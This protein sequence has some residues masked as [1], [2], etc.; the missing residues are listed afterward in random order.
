[1]KNW[2]QWAER[3]PVLGSIAGWPK[4][5]QLGAASALLTL[6]IGT[7]LW[8]GRPDY[9]VLFANLEDRDG[10]AIVT[11]LG[12]MNIPYKLAGTGQAI[13]VPA[14]KVHEVRLL[15]AQQGLPRSGETGFGLLDQTRFGASQ[16][17]EQI[18]Y[19]RALEGELAHS[20]EAVHAVQSARVHL[21]LPRESLFVRERQPPT[22]SVLL[23][24]YPGRSLT[25]AQVSAI[26]WL[27]SSSVPHLTS[28]KVSVVDQNGRLLTPP[29]GE[30]GADGSRR[31]LVNEI[32]QR[33]AQRILTLLSPL[34]GAS[35]VQAQVSADVD[36]VQRE[37][38]SEVYRPNQLPGEAAVRSKQTSASTQHN[39][40]PPQ[41][42]PGAL[43]NQPPVNATAPIQ[44]P[45][46]PVPVDG[47]VEASSELAT[48]GAPQQ[49]SG[50][51]RQDATINYEVDR[52]IRHTKQPLGT[53]RRLS[54]AV[55]INDRHL[56]DRTES[57][58][59]ETL[60]RLTEL[61]RQAMGYSAERG[62][63]LSVVSMPF[64]DAGAAAVPLWQNPIYLDYGMDLIRYLLIALG[65]YL[66]W[67]A[68]V[69]PLLTSSKAAEQAGA[70]PAGPTEEEE[71]DTAAE[72]LA[73]E[74]SRYE[75]N[76]KTARTLAEKDPRA[77]AMVLRAWMEKTHDNV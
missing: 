54:V 70:L 72:R 65:V 34:V 14:D 26:S 57:V 73:S 32:E 63:T 18:T 19:Q 4:P 77:V 27:V 47:A 74:L 22:A 46:L 71:R 2:A 37:E 21:A 13:M 39:M 48:A 3:F 45:A 66:A 62:D 68:L 1:M 31:S 36:F 55:V 41:G 11:A 69:R 16:F 58:S 40:L 42:V 76:L 67:R 5:V 33:T 56:E 10:G 12:Q 60:S 44:A 9:R 51:T 6:I 28:E 7:L 50:A 35:N 8:A 59:A 17:S 49:G 52:T 43:T 23:T 64:D 38:T 30:A 75:D 29:A 61:V 53:L 25:D 20:I 15:L 24:L